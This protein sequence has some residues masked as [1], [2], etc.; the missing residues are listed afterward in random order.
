MV[1]SRLQGPAVRIRLG[2]AVLGGS[3]LVAM[4][5]TAVT[6]APHWA[7]AAPAAAGSGVASLATTTVAPS[8]LAIEFA[9]PTVTATFF[10]KH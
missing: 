5:A 1:S 8:T 10:G 2:A 9:K 3:A 6:A 4:A 7:P